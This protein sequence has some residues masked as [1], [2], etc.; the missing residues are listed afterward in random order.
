MPPFLKLLI[1]LKVSPLAALGAAMLLCCNFLWF[2]G[3]QPN[4]VK[5][6]RRTSSENQEGAQRSKV[7]RQ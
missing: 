3:Q 1:Y 5:D 4:R 2:P 6:Q 7:R